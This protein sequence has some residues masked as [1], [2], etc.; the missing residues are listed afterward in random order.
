M[1]LTAPIQMSRIRGCALASV[2]FLAAAAA[3]QDVPAVA[4]QPA[5]A[6]AEFPGS[7]PA[8]VASPQPTSR[9]ARESWLRVIRDDVNVRARPDTASVA[10]VRV[11]RGAVLHATGQDD[12]G[13][14]RIIP[15]EGVFSYVAGEHI[16]REGA[17]G[18]VDVQSG[19]LRVRVG[20][21]V[22]A[23]D[24]LQSDVHALLERGAR[25]R[26]LG[27]QGD[28]LKIAPPPKV[29]LYISGDLVEPISAELAG[30]LQA[31]AVATSRP[32]PTIAERAGIPT[33]TSTPA[34]PDLNGAWGQ[35]LVKIEQ[36]IAAEGRKPLLEQGWADAL[37]ALRPIAEQREEPM[38]AQLAAAWMR[39]LEDRTAE[40]QTAREAQEI[41]ARAERAQ[42]RQAREMERIG[43]A[44]Q[45][46]TRPAFAAQGEL[47]QS[48]TGTAQPGRP[49]YKLV[50]PVTRRLETYIELET[51]AQLDLQAAVGQYLG[52]RGT[53]QAAP[54]LAADI[55]RVTDIVP[56]APTGRAGA[57]SRPAAGP[58][59]TP[60]AGR[61]PTSQSARQ[62][63]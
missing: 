36:E 24:P 53:R 22:H 9:G 57:T 32:T 28:W 37:A 20:S 23:L 58:I 31:L 8:A 45:A 56:L 21:L 11:P 43:E 30:H 51:G 12:F 35:R 15:P 61:S 27:A 52:V 55:V 48:Y 16:R 50:N 44:R 33:P 29:R 6:A 10:V 47:L 1:S 34:G 19:T 7:Q 49:Q 26:I 63:R 60:A 42:N 14:Y 41:V 5:T 17:E 18:V 25:V 38:V 2:A 40:Q 54:A 39:Q 13:W 62:V 3:A 59:P 46:A 4:T